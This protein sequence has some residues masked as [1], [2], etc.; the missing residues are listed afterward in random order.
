M[1]LFLDNY[2]L[3]FLGIL[4]LIVLMLKFF[5][6]WT[7]NKIGDGLNYLIFSFKT[8]ISAAAI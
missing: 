2:F 1:K 5:S 6:S 3:S 8:L 4:C 7:D